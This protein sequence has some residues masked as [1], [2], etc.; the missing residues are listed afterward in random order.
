[1]GDLWMV[2]YFMG[3]I[4]GTVGPLPYD[5][6]VCRERAVEIMAKANDVVTPS[7]HSKKDVKFVCEF[8]NER[9]VINYKGSSAYDEI[10]PKK[11]SE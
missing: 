1:M 8:H 6:D 3:Q 9:P 7:G 10:Q 2:I 11:P 4:G 5:I